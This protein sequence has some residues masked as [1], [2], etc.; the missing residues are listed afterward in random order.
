MAWSKRLL[1]HPVTQWV[2]CALL[3]GYIALV[4]LTSRIE[5]HYDEAALPYTSGEKQAVFAFW[6]GRL[7]MLAP[8]IPPG[9]PMHVLISRHRDGAMISRIIQWFGIR[10][11]EGSSSKGSLKALRQI[12]ALVAEGDNIAITPDGPRGPFQK[13]APGVS[14]VAHATG[15]PVIPVAYSAVRCKR[16][17]SWDKF[18]LP[19][20]FTRIAV[21]ASAPLYIEHDD[22]SQLLYV[23]EQLNKATETADRLTGHI[24]EAEH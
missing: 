23:E 8:M 10:T 20:P 19:L 18:M 9:R 17:G 1:K 24:I 13:A 22:T 7:G 4:R 16:L 2:I 5:K 14:Y 6:H 11:V 15:L 21:V 3:A 12:H